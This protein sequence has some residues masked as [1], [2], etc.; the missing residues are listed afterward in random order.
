MVRL[1]LLTA[2][3]SL[4]S[5]A[6]TAQA[7]AEEP[8]PV[9]II[10]FGG[11]NGAFG[12]LDCNEDDQGT[13]IDFSHFLAALSAEREKGH[14]L[15][16]SPGNM[17]GD[18]PMFEFNLALGEPGV[19]RLARLLKLTGMEA[20][21]P[22]SGPSFAR[23]VS[24]A[25]VDGL[26]FSDPA[27]SVSAAA[28]RAREDQGADLVVALVN[29][30]A[31]PGASEET[32]RFL[33]RV[34]GVD[35]VIA[36]GLRD[37]EDPLSYVEIL[38]AGSGHPVLIG[39]PRAPDFLGLLE[40]T[41]D[42]ETGGLVTGSVQARSIQVTSCVQH[43]ETAEYLARTRSAFCSQGARLLGNGRLEPALNRD[44]FC[45][46]VMEIM[47]RKIGADLSVLSYDS[48]RI[49]PTAVLEG[50]LSAELLYRVFAPHEL[51]LLEAK[52][53]VLEPFVR[54][55]LSPDASSHP[56]FLLRGGVLVDNKVKVNG[57]PLNQ[58]R[59]ENVPLS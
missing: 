3:L 38:S 27:D 37:A 31:R 6:W 52:G 13:S 54:G 9:R 22:A 43:E 40:M 33:K 35:V 36:G 20:L 21:V 7:R 30:E 34:R 4:P 2:L 25:N 46:Y 44:A 32:L 45:H 49:P 5:L 53:R 17:L 26:V 18:A 11:L 42:R 50:P 41:V 55:Y 39:S 23:F 19:R 56:E 24:P 1:A 15:V 12:S 59:T 58:D 29:L 57:R 16:L 48:L 10:H 8:I 14:C 28:L 47:R 51:V